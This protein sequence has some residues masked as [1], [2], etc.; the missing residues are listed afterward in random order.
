MSSAS[1]GLVLFRNVGTVAAI[2]TAFEFV[3]GSIGLLFLGPFLYGIWLSK[4][5]IRKRISVKKTDIRARLLQREFIAF[6]IGAWFAVSVA[7]V[8]SS[9]D[10]QTLVTDNE[11]RSTTCARMDFLYDTRSVVLIQPPPRFAVDE[12]SLD[13][14]SQINC[15]ENGL[16]S[17]DLG[18]TTGIIKNGKGAGNAPVCVSKDKS[19]AYTPSLIEK[20]TVKLN[21]IQVSAPDIGYGLSLDEP[22]VSLLP[23]NTS[24]GTSRFRDNDEKYIPLPS[25]ERM[26]ITTFPIRF[27]ENWAITGTDDYNVS[28]VVMDRICQSLE[29]ERLPV[30]FPYDI[31]VCYEYYDHLTLSGCG[32]RE[33]FVDFGYT[34]EQDELGVLIQREFENNSSYTATTDISMVSLLVIED[35]YVDDDELPDGIDF[36]SKSAACP[37]ITL[38]IKY[39]LIPT[40]FA[41]R[42]RSKRRFKKVKQD[43]EYILIPKRFEV[44]SGKCESTIHTLGLS[45]LIHSANAE[46]QSNE[47]AEMNRI[48]RYHAMMISLGRLSFPIDEVLATAGG[49]NNSCTVRQV[50]QVTVLK[51]DLSFYTLLIVSGVCAAFVVTVVLFWCLFPKNAWEISPLERLQRYNPIQVTSM[52]KGREHIVIPRSRSLR[53]DGGNTRSVNR[54]REIDE[55]TEIT[56]EM[57]NEQQPNTER[58]VR[59]NAILPPWMSS[60]DISYRILPTTELNATSG[61]GLDYANVFDEEQ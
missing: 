52:E 46:W 32:Y 57:I 1:T 37:D 43:T 2:L 23:Y 8:E 51:R 61:R 33:D 54:K 16:F 15:S 30:V 9:L 24:A 25:C 27:F 21:R 18:D 6:C 53:Q 12:W 28:R 56:I 36:L 47:L 38:R 13:V 60:P 41:L 11:I 34:K 14:A 58:G 20:G 59:Q 44:V 35:E 3:V 29:P 40:S 39:I 55:K 19:L 5:H 7:L 50:T 10:E 49:N 17:I 48:D 31:A 22:I 42:G 45:A 26:N 4:L